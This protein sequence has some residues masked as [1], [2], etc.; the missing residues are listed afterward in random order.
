MLIDT[1]GFGY[2]AQENVAEKMMSYLHNALTF[3]FVVN[4]AIP[5]GIQGNKVLI[6]KIVLLVNLYDVIQSCFK[7]ARKKHNVMIVDT[8]GVRYLTR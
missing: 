6:F 1:P 4:V 5:D 2:L 7:Y 8:P 3:V